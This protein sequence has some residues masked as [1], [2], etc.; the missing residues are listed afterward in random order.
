MEAHI[1]VSAKPGPSADASSRELAPAERLDDL[2][3]IIRAYNDVTDKLQRSH[4]ALHDE[5]SRL[6]HELSGANAQLQRGKRLAALGEM[7][8]GIAHEIRNPLGAIQLYAG[9]IAQDLGA[10]TTR[11]Q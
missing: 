4:E 11:D 1:E 5:V 2:A 6:Q 10:V 9:M 3:R 8:A 7:A